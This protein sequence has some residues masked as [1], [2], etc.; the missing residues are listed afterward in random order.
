LTDSQLLSYYQRCQ[1]VVFPQE[2]DFGLVPLEAQACGKPVI[3]YRAGGALESIIEGK[4][5]V[6]FYPQTTEALREKILRYKD[7]KILREKFKPE[8]CRKQAEKF[9]I[10]IFKKKWKTYLKNIYTL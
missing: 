1:A 4:T 2:E 10:K 3:A 8:D 5:G 7:I 9:N 6:F